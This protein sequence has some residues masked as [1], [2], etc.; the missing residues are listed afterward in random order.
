[1]KNKKIKLN[2]LCIRKESNPNSP[3]T[4]FGTSFQYF[5]TL[6]FHLNMVSFIIVDDPCGIWIEIKNSTPNYLDK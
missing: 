5:S 4:K 2:K 1:M 3:I 6:I